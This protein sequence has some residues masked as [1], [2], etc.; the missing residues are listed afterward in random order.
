V[1]VTTRARS[2]DCIQLGARSACAAS[3]AVVGGA[4]E[5]DPVELLLCEIA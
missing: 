5:H 1:I 2:T 4:L 3:A